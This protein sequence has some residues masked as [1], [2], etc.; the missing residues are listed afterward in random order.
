MPE[1]PWTEVTQTMFFDSELEKAGIYGNC[2]QAAVASVLNL[3]LEAVPHFSQFVWWPQ[4]IELWARG[5]GLSSHWHTIEEIPDRLCV[6]GGKSPRGAKGGHVV[7]AHRG[8]IVWDPH[9]SRDGLTSVEDCVWFEPWVGDEDGCWMC[10][11]MI[12]TQVAD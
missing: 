6:V 1:L 11:P 8:E 12:S 4:A 9:P 3:P 5:R 2:M 7:V 10:R